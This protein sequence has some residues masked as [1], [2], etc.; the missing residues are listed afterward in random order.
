MT[1]LEA[2]KSRHAVRSFSKIPIKEETKATLNQVIAEC[3]KES[4]LN[5][6]LVTDAPKAFDCFKAHYGKFVN[7]NNYL[8]IVGKKGFDEKA[9]YYGEKIVLEAQKLGLNSCW[10]V[11]TYK[12]I[13]NA[14]TIN[15][16]EKIY[17]VVPLGYGTVQGI[18]HK[19]KDLKA[20]SNIGDD[21]P[22][23]FKDGVNAALLAPTAINQQKFYFKYNNGKVIAKPGLAIYS[24]IDL[25]I[26]KYHFEVGADKDS[27]V[28]EN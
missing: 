1:T 17:I 12:K 18:Q 7:V 24:K 2:I 6:Q 21:S 9:G 28:F 10:V 22:S 15:K 4:G 20:V 16:G 5:I 26:A 19:S 8:A 11:M 25:G 13:P 14:F 27:S 3:N 23:W